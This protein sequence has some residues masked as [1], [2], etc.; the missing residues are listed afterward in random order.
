[1]K[2]GLSKEDLE[3]VYLEVE[4]MQTLKSIESEGAF[5]RLIDFRQD[6]N[7]FYIVTEYL[8]RSLLSYLT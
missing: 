5:V 6:Y 2:K 7:N 4:I 8:E 3:N 1:M